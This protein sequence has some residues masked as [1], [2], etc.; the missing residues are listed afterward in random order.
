MSVPGQQGLVNLRHGFSRGPEVHHEF[1]EHLAAGWVG[2]DAGQG[3]Q[4]LYGVGGIGQDPLA[5]L[6]HAPGP[7]GS[8]VGPGHNGP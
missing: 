5:Q 7:H 6:L 4:A 2:G 1:L 3:G 8:Q